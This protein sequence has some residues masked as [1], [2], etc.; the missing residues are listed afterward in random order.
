[1]FHKTF[2]RLWYL[3]EAVDYNVTAN[4]VNRYPPQAEIPALFYWKT[5]IEHLT[6]AENW[7]DL[8]Y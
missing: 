2:D 7:V 4:I 5:N 6:G 1:M 8:G 3:P